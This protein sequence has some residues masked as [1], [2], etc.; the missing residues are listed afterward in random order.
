MFNG[1]NEESSIY[2]ENTRLKKQR[3]AEK[4]VYRQQNQIGNKNNTRAI[5]NIVSDAIIQKTEDSSMN[6]ALSESLDDLF[7]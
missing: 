5:C 1:C 4:D 6:C 3:K 7:A 2:A